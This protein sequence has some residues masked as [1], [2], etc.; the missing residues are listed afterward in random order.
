MPV[1]VPA[2]VCIPPLATPVTP[3]DNEKPLVTIQD[4][5]GSFVAVR[6][7]KPLLYPT[8]LRGHGV[9][10]AHL[11]EDWKERLRVLCLEIVIATV[12]DTPVSLADDRKSRRTG[13]PGPDSGTPT[14]WS[15][16]HNSLVVSELCNWLSVYWANFPRAMSYSSEILA[17]Q[18]YATLCP[19]P[20][21]TFHARSVA[22][23]YTMLAC[24]VVP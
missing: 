24:L 21:S 15:D 1:T 12:S 18:Y 13:W 17:L 20:Q 8:E 16:Y 23:N 10:L 7:R 9:N 2:T 6:L 4:H 19:L 14:I 3:R 11:G 5:K 22:R